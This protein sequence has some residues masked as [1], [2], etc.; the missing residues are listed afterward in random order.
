MT[1]AYKYCIQSPNGVIVFNTLKECLP[2]IEDY[3][4]HSFITRDVLNNYIIN[5]RPRHQLLFKDLIVNREKKIIQ[6]PNLAV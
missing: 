4:K 1:K 5:K 2:F 6:P 3:V